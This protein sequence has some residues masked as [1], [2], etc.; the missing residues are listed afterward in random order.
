VVI[1]PNNFLKYR[2]K[3]ARIKVKR[4]WY[5]FGVKIGSDKNKF[6]KTS[7]HETKLCAKNTGRSLYVLKITNVNRIN[8]YLKN[9]FMNNQL[10]YTDTIHGK[11]L[12]H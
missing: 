3:W 8:A 5:C 6:L 11:K 7:A 1:T 10:A 2:F 9:Q 12:S 4:K